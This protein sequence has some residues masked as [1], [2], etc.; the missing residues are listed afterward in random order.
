M[1]QL[2][3]LSLDRVDTQALY[4]SADEYRAVVHRVAEVLARI[5]EYDHATALHH[6]A[7]KSAGA[8]TDDDGAA[9]LIDP[10]ARTHVAPAD[11]IAAT[12]RG[13]ECRSGVFLN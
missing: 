2:R 13:A 4:F 6:E 11:K 1:I 8:T 3:H 9:L 10:R 5:A 7:G 12:D